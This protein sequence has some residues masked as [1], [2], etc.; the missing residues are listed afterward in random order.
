MLSFLS[1]KNTFILLLKEDNINCKLKENKMSNWC[2]NSLKVTGPGVQDFL[3]D[4][5]EKKEDVDEY[6]PQHRM[7]FTKIAPLEEDTHTSR[8]KQWGVKGEPEEVSYVAEGKEFAELG[9]YTAWN[10]PS[11]FVKAASVKYPTTT[12]LLYYLE[13]GMSFAGRKVFVAGEETEDC[14]VSD[15]QDTFPPDK[16]PDLYIEGDNEGDQYWIANIHE[17]FDLLDK[18]AA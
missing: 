10:E 3:G 11:E 2:E 7:D 9:F 17:I 12:F 6:E 13:T 8:V 5:L 18:E 4:V 15:I 14:L 1:I 16:F